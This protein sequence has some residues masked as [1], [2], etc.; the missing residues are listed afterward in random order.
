MT[1][2]TEDPENNGGKEQGMDYRFSG[3]ALLAAG[4]TRTGGVH[5]KDTKTR[6]SKIN[7]Q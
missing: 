2:A 1:I 6:R 4:L 7:E 3:P 5:Y